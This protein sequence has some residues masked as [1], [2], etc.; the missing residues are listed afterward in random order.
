M[1]N[2]YREVSN[3]FNNKASVYDDVDNQLYWVLSDLFFKEVLKKEVPRLIAGKKEIKLLDAGAGTGRWTIFFYQLFNENYIISGELVDISE[4]MLDEAKVKLVKNNLN[5]KFKCL[6][7]N[8]EEMKEIR[9][10]RYDVSLSFY[11]VISFVENPGKALAE[12]AKKL[13]N[14]GVHISIVAN[15]YHSYYFSILTNQLNELDIIKNQSK[16]RFNESMPH[17]HC[18]TPDELRELYI[19]NGFSRVKIVGGPNFFYPGM[20]ETYTHGNTDSIK[21]A[22]S[23]NGTFK[24]ILEVELDNYEKKDIIGRGNVLMAIAIK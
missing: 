11:N 16:I 10:E 14:G 1:N 22:L 24:K 5:S 3:Y 7:G 12:I 9:N 2:Y 20:E 21:N 8:I 6:F 4:K 23:S 17:I 13:K 19:N 18:Y 15:K